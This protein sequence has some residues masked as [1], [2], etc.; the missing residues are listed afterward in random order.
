[1]S[2]KCPQCDFENEDGSKF[3]KN[4]NVP[5]SKQDYSED[6]LYTKKKGNKDQPFELI[7]DEEDKI[8]N[9]IEKENKKRYLPE[10]GCLVLL[11]LAIVVAV[12]FIF[13]PSSG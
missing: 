12:F 13:K 2:I 3:C 8:R 4:C 9:K 1:M 11:V 5:L 10:M 6:N 7:S